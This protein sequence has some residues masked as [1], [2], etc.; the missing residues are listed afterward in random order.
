MLSDRCPVCPVSNVGVLWPNDLMDEN[1]TWHAYRPWPRPH[2][3]RWGPSSPT[4]RGTAASHCRNL[5]LHALH[6]S[7]YNPRPMILVAKRLDG[8][9]CRKLGAVPILGRAHLTQ[10]GLGQGLPRYQVVSSS[11]QPFGHNRHSSSSSKI[12]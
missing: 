9:R 11:I 4:E 8:S 2:R 3:V 6:T 1:E 10:C 12:L 7:V 5:R